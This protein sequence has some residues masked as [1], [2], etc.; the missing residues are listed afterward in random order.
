MNNSFEN[1]KRFLIQSMLILGLFLFGSVGFVSGQSEHDGHDGGC[2]LAGTP[3]QMQ[4]GTIK[5]IEDV[6]I[7]DEVVG[8]DIDKKEFTVNVV[9][10]LEAPVVD[11]WFKIFLDNGKVLKTTDD[12][13]IYIKEYN[14]WASMDPEATRKKSDYKID[15]QE[16]QVNQHI[17]DLNGEYRRIVHISSVSEKIQTYNLKGV[18]NNDTF[19]A[20]E[21]LVHNKTCGNSDGDGDGDGDGDS[22]GEKGDGHACF[23]PGTPIQM[24]D[25]TSKVI[26]NVK[27]GDKIIGYDINKKEFTENIVEALEAPIAEEWFKIILN[28]G[29]I[30]RTTDDHP[31]Y[32]KE[33]DSWASID[34][35][36]TW[37]NS[38]HKMKFQQLKNG[39]HVL[40]SNGKYSQILFILNVP[41]EVQTYNLKKV[42]DNSTFFAEGVLVHNKGDGPSPSPPP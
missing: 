35:E 3:I 16:L 32:V 6:Q 42:S 11:E 33:Y 29:R 20:G 5:A 18:S 41:E 1:K 8:Y 4:D 9:E 17:L 31:I 23:L 28:N 34:P 40:D 30:L 27:V 25:G 2:F 39:Q 36:A 19:F 10:E 21:V 37:E 12:H 24:R 38:N 7:G 26:E 14:N 13:P 15:A 22:G